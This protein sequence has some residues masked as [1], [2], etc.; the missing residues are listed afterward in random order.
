MKRS[1]IAISASLVP[2][3]YIMVVLAGIT[4]YYIRFWQPIREIRPIIFDLSFL[5]FLKFSLVIAL[6]WLI[7][8]WIGGLYAMSSTRRTIDEISKIILSCSTAVMVLM[9]VFFFSRSLFD[10]RF[11]ILAVWLISIIYVIIG[12]GVIRMIQHY[13]YYFN[14]GM[15]RLIVIGKSELAQE[16]I[17]SFQ[18]N[19][20]MGYKVVQRF[21]G[22]TEEDQKTLLAMK[23]DDKFDEILVATGNLTEKQL[24]F[25]NDFSYINH[26]TLKYVADIFEFPISNF[27][28]SNISG[29]PIVELKKTRLDGWGRVYKRAFDII[30][31]SMI[32]IL[33]SPVMLIVALAIKIDSRGSLFFSYKRIG[34]RGK[35]FTY[36]KF[37]SMRK[38]AHKLRFD[39]E[40]LKQHKNLRDGSPM[41]K[42]QD[43]P[44]ITRVGKVIRKFSLDELPELFNVWIGKMSLVGPRPHE[45]EEV[46]KYESYHKKVLTIKPGMTGMAQVSG[47]SDLD[48][49]EE[50]RLDVWYMENW[51]F[52]LDLMILFKTPFAVLKKRKAE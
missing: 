44:R 35:P 7:S 51:S 46:A 26:V 23:M 25:L 28:V 45:I 1:E 19:I 4:S 49:D 36:F 3:D 32:I 52:K 33:L 17:D 27:E 42:F 30:T 40:F 8:F 12:R 20:K 47:R 10:S 15:H 13:L 18:K 5:F 11:I 41:M 9:F 2:I 14:F 39:Q 22:L 21:D 16:V 50:V 6:I 37:R 38:D 29:F 24:N 34:E 43:D 48:F 31:S